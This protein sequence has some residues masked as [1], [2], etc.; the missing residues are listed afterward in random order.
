MIVPY[1]GDFYD[2]QRLKVCGDLGQ[3]LF[4]PYD[5]RD[6]ESIRKAMKYS[7]VV[8]NL[9]GRE[10]ETRNFNF[11]DVN[12]KIPAKLARIA[13]EMGVQRFIHISSINASDKPQSLFLPGGSP[14]LKTKREGER[15]VLKENPDATIIRPCEIYGYGDHMINYYNCNLRKAGYKPW[16]ALW[17]KGNET[18]RS[19][20]FINDLTSGIMACLADPGTRGETFEAMGPEQFLL[21]DLVD[22]MHDIMDKDEQDWGYSR[23]EL[24]F[25]PATFAK[26]TACSLMPFGMGLKY[27]K[28]CTLERLERSQ[29]SEI[30]EGLPSITDLGVKL[31]RVEEKMPWE[32]DKY[33]AFKYFNY[34]LAYDRL[35]PRK[36]V[37]LNPYEA[38]SIINSVEDKKTMQKLIGL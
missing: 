29:L 22:W 10:F 5:V 2:A 14:W 8:I 19:P 38:K 32:L 3:V 36:L 13:K 26:A 15:A 18:V 25:S 20:L 21:A 37:A 7:D 28:A 17:K 24:M 33:R 23:Q 34:P 35:V 12:V 4:Q 6:E 9:I 31:H 1:R 27:F 16:I 30:S 11:Q